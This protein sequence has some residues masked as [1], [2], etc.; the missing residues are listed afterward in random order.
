MTAHYST[1]ISPQNTRCQWCRGLLCQSRVLYTKYCG[2]G[3]VRVTFM[4]MI[5]R[6]WNP[7]SHA[8]YASK[9][10][11]GDTYFMTMDSYFEFTPD[12]TGIRIIWRK[13]GRHQT[14]IQNH[15]GHAGVT[16]TSLPVRS[17][18]LFY[19]LVCMGGNTPR[20]THPVPPTFRSLPPP[21]SFLLLCPS[22]RMY[23]FDS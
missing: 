7:K 12:W 8:M 17:R 18:I 11:G 14:I 10:W 1:S 21:V 22:S 13:P 19:T 15:P 3:Q 20:T 4:F 5:L 6:A 16:V 2:S 9:W 23:S